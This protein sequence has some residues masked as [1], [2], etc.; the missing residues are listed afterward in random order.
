VLQ[1][2]Q[3]PQLL[4]ELFSGSIASLARRKTLHQ[5]RQ[6]RNVRCLRGLTSL[7]SRHQLLHISGRVAAPLDCTTLL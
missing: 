1:L 7:G 2:L 3:Y 4:C 6:L 5:L